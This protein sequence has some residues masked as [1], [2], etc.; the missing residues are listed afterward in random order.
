MSQLKEERNQSKFSLQDPKLEREKR[1]LS[2]QL[3]SQENPATK[4][5][6][7]EGNV[8]EWLM[9]RGTP[10]KTE[11]R[12]LR[13]REGNNLLVH[14]CQTNSLFFLFFFSFFLCF[15]FSSYFYFFLFLSCYSSFLFPIFKFS[16]LSSS[17]HRCSCSYTQQGLLFIVPA[18]TRFY[19]F[20]P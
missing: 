1:L 17:S 18:V 8:L 13:E 19:Y 16:I 10:F 5:N 12:I 7:F 15:H 20:S 11:D 9:P 4:I 14:A 3:I 2:T 6:H